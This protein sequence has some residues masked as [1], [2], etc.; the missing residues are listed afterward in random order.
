GTVSVPVK[1]YPPLRLKDRVKRAEGRWRMETVYLVGPDPDC[2]EAGIRAA[3]GVATP[4]RAGTHVYDLRDAVRKGG[5]HHAIAA[6]A[7][8]AIA[9]DQG[10]RHYRLPH[11][12]DAVRFDDFGAFLA[13]IGT[14]IA[15]LRRL[16]GDRSGALDAID[17]ITQNPAQR[18]KKS[19]NNVIN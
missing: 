16:C 5:T 6:T 18:P 14:D 15:T 2:V 17:R 1:G 9:R 10:W 19:D 7:L 3:E 8:V 4:M 13:E 12:D 11:T